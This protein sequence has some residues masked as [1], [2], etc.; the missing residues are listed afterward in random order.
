MAQKHFYH[1]N[2]VF[3]CRQRRYEPSMIFATVQL[4]TRD[5][6]NCAMMPLVILGPVRI[7]WGLFKENG[8]TQFNLWYSWHKYR[9]SYSTMNFIPALGICFRIAKSCTRW[10]G[11]FKGSHRI[12]NGR[13]FLKKTS[14]P[15]S[16]IKAFQMNLISAGSISLDSTFKALK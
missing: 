10:R 7:N 15:L 1:K 13:I 9:L 3:H 11:I 14:A 4:M 5:V 16:S 2:V 6:E 8:E 12:G